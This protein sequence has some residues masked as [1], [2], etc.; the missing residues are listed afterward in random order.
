[1]DALRR[2]VRAAAAGAAVL[3]A[4]GAAAQQAEPA[5]S[6]L[7]VARAGLEDPNFGQSVVLAS[8]ADSGETVGVIL[9]RPTRRK[10]ENGEPLYFGGPVMGEVLVAL[11]RADAA[12]PA[13]AFHVLDKVYLTLHPANIDALL[14]HP[15]PSHRLYAGFAGWAPGQL[16]AEIERGDW[17]VLAPSEEILFRADTRGMWLELWQKAYGKHAAAQLF[18]RV[19]GVY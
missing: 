2:Y 18:H 5:N 12:P 8:Q 16:E 7:L 15:G 6:V 14:A 13:S 11:F 4:H 1:M 9:N 3:L 17:M 19:K 10:H